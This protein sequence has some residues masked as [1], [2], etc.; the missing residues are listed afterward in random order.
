MTV[1]ALGWILRLLPARVRDWLGGLIVDHVFAHEK[2][3]RRIARRNE[4]DR[5]KESM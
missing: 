3:M 1:R 2:E 5:P 4:Q